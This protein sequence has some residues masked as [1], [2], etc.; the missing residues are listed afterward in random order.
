MS[1]DDQ[2]YVVVHYTIGTDLQSF[3]MLAIPQ[4]LQKNIPVF[5]ARKNIQPMDNGKC[6]EIEFILIANPER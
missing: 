4:A 5:L 6:D 3:M 2:V 1:A